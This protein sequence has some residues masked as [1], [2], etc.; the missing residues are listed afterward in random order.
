MKMYMTSLIHHRCE[1]LFAE[2]DISSIFCAS[3][4]IMATD[5]DAHLSLTSIEIFSITFLSLGN[6]KILNQAPTYSVCP[7]LLYKY[8]CYD[9][10]QS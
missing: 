1:D 5:H 2:S 10:F 9:H 6:Y 3:S 4:N 8:P 7:F